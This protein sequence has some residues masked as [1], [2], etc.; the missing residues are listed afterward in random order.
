MGFI[1]NF[2]FGINFLNN[3]LL[4]AESENIK[5]LII[6]NKADLA[7]STDFIK[8]ITELYNINLG[9]EIVTLSAITNCDT[10]KP[11]LKDRQSLLIGQSGVGK[12]TITNMIIPTANAKIG[13]I[14]KSEASG[15][16][17][18]TNAT[19]YHIDEGST[20]IDC[21]GLQEFGLYHLDI[22]ELPHLFPELRENLGQCRFR[23]C[24]HINEPDCAI[25]LVYNQNKIDKMRFNLFISL[26]KLL[27]NKKT[28]IKT[29]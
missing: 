10:L 26:T 17:T 15:C 23:D 7:E 5:P 3:C 29:K 6:I 25:S 11:I 20:L 16:H 4:F 24:R 19:L 9:Y 12:S 13:E 1:V 28:Y 2:P 21:P 27:I 14:A 18:T 8:Q 22:D